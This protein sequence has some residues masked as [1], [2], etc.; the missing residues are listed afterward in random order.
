MHACKHGRELAFWR[1]ALWTV[2]EAPPVSHASGTASGHNLP[3]AF[4]SV[5]RQ[6]AGAWKVQVSGRMGEELFGRSQA[7][8]CHLHQPV[9]TVHGCRS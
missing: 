7:V 9:Q 5:K 1:C 8:R 4:S 2:E 6:C 3:T